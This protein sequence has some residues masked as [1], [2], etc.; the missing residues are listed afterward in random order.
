MADRWTYRQTSRTDFALSWDGH[1]LAVVRWIVPLLHEHRTMVRLIEGL[2]SGIQQPARTWAPL[3][4]NPAAGV[5]FVHNGRPCGELQ[6]TPPS[7]RPIRNP[8]KW[9]VRI[10]DGLNRDGGRADPVPEPAPPRQL[11][12]VS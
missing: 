2:N 1:D 4:T 12:R 7:G 10:I 11:R 9:I 8:E 5:V 6:W 3:W